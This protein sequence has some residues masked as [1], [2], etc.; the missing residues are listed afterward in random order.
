MLAEHLNHSA[1]RNLILKVYVNRHGFIL[2]EN[3]LRM[4]SL[5]VIVG[6]VFRPRRSAVFKLTWVSLSLLLLYILNAWVHFNMGD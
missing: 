3:Y 6:L 2:M 4:S 1:Q 5:L